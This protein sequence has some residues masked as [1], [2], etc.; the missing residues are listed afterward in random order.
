MRVIKP[1]IHRFRPAR[2]LASVTATA[3][4]TAFLS[5]PALADFNPRSN[6]VP[7]GLVVI[8]LPNSIGEGT[9]EVYFRGQ[10]V[11]TANRAYNSRSDDRWVAWIGLGQDL[12]AGK[13]SIDIRQPGGRSRNIYIDVLDPEYSGD[14]RIASKQPL[15]TG[16]TPGQKNRIAQDKNTLMNLVKR[17]QSG[18]PDKRAFLHPTNGSSLLKPFGKR[19]FYNQQMI[20]NH[21]GVDL[22]GQRVIAPANGRVVLIDDLFYQGKHVVIDHGSG[23]FTQYSHLDAVNFRIRP[24]QWIS[25][26]EEIGKIGRSGKE[27]IFGKSFA[28]PIKKPHLHFSV[29]LNGV[30]VDPE[31]FLNP[32][33]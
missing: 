6:P 32:V 24:G 12:G 17:W 14:K 13:H 26:G 29:N 22:A 9:P 10:R 31:L 33:Q 25:R 15:R 16:L 19:M 23:L 7:G 1:F 8:E 30:Y 21:N 27:I 2:L 4:I 20:Y 3:A 28:S 11:Y 5:L 18:E